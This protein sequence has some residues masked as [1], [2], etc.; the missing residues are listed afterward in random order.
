MKFIHILVT[1]G[2]PYGYA[3]FCDSRTEMEGF[4]FWKKGYW[5]SHLGKR[6]YHISAL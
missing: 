3:P 5:K 6:K 1:T 4:R 2:N